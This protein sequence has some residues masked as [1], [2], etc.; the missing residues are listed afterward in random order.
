M[1]IVQCGMVFDALIHMGYKNWTAKKELITVKC[2]LF[3][4]RQCGT[5][6]R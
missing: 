3:V 6:P 2:W 4:G 1:F 5:F